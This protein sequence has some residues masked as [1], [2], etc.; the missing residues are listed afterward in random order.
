MRARTTIFVGTATSMGHNV[1]QYRLRSNSGRGCVAVSPA[2]RQSRSTSASSNQLAGA[3][4]AVERRGGP[5]VWLIPP[6]PSPAAGPTGTARGARLPQ[7][8]GVARHDHRGD[9][10]QP[11]DDRLR[12]VEP[13]HM[14]VAGGE[15]T[16]RLGE[17][18]IFLDREEQL[19]HRLIEAPAEEMRAPIT[20]ETVPTRARG[21][22]RSDAR[23]ARSRCRAG[24]PIA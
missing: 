1:A 16:I 13:T 19:R 4:H 5:A 6:R 7:V 14:G 21:L 9:G 18:R 22:R 10:A 3:P 15:I 12:V 11:R 2:L 17:V 23:H 20:Q 8:A 24:P